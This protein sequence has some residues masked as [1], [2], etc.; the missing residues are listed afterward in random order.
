MKESLVTQAKLLATPVDYDKLI[1]EGFLEKD[2]AWFKVK[3]EL[4]KHVLAQVRSI[5]T[6]R[7]GD[8]LVKL[9]NSWNKAQQVY[10]KITGKE[11]NE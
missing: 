7:K 2:G 5:K 4:P 9:P 8:C 10:R 11:Y 1:K 6:N 3:K